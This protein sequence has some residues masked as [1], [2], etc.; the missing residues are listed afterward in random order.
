VTAGI[1]YEVR[2]GRCVRVGLHPSYD[3]ALAAAR[4]REGPDSDAGA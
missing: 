2:D 4:D 3:A 1:E